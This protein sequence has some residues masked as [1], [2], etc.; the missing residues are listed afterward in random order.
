MPH[1]DSFKWCWCRTRAKITYKWWLRLTR[2]NIAIHI[3]PT[4]GVFCMH[5]ADET[6]YREERVFHYLK[7]F[8][9]KSSGCV[10]SWLV[11]RLSCLSTVDAHYVTVFCRLSLVRP[12]FVLTERKAPPPGHVCH[13]SDD[14]ASGDCYSRRHSLVQQIARV[15]H[16]DL[17]HY[18]QVWLTHVVS[19]RVT[20]RCFDTVNSKT[21]WT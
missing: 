16:Y 21:Y 7:A 18:R 17:L 9:K 20:R 12:C 8:Y 11:L 3:L 14:R 10:Q 13:N 5:Q 1:S 15:H 6:G 4:G 2:F 19:P